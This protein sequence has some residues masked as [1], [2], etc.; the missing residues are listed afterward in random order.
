[1][2]GAP[3]VLAGLAVASVGLWTLRVALTARGMKLASSCVAALE[4]VV[5]AMAF[6]NLVTDLGSVDRLIGYALG[7]AAGTALGLLANDRLTRGHSELHLIV[8]A[9]V[10]DLLK[11]VHARGWTATSSVGEGPDGQVTQIWITA[12]DIRVP[13]LL[14][15]IGEL[16]PDAL[17]TLRRLQAARA[18][19]SSHHDRSD[20]EAQRLPVTKRLRNRLCPW[21]ESNLRRTV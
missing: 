20:V 3:F 5:F 9:D 17:W 7:V 2:S 6:S 15:D 19:P 16:S 1:M 18:D 12:D 13:A 14:A 21:Q 10:P 8:G 4:A 11:S